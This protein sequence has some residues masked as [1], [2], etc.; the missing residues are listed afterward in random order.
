MTDLSGDPLPGATGVQRSGTF[1]L[2]AIRLTASSVERSHEEN[3]P[4]SYRRPPAVS[5]IPEQDTPLHHP[6]AEGSEA[7]IV[8]D[9]SPEAVDEEE[10]SAGAD[11]SRERIIAT[12]E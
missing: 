8:G 3:P 5:A 2:S 4:P 1:N 11:S 6:L 7:T 10:T 9:L 12:A